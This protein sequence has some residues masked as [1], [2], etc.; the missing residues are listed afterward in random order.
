MS[1]RA[2]TH[3]KL[4]AYNLTIMNGHHYLRY[5]INKHDVSTYFKFS[6]VRNPYDRF[7]S[8]WKVKQ[9]KFGYSLD[10]FID[11]V[12]ARK[13]PWTAL[14]AQYTWISDGGSNLLTDHLMRYENYLIDIK[15]TLR[16]LGLPIISL[17]HLRKSDRSP[18]YRVYYKND[19]QIDFVTDYYKQD[20]T[21]FRYSF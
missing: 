10:E 17:P 3:I 2:R 11:L 16:K 1:R 7:I 4:K 8:L 12:K 5:L 20:L 19:K 14:K 13:L 21:N 15:D 9:E 18:N 6:I